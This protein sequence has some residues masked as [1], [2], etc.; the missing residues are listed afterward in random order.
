MTSTLIAPAD[1]ATPAQ[2]RYLNDLRVQRGMAVYDGPTL[3]KREASRLIDTTKALPIV[4]ATAP[5]VAGADAFASIPTGKY[6]FTADAGH[7]AFAQVNRP[8]RGRWVGRVFV[9]LL[10]G[11]P[12]DWRK[13]AQRG[14][15]ATTILAKI[16]AQGAEVSMARYGHEHGRC[17]ACESP[18]SDPVSI[19]RG[20]GPVCARRR[21]W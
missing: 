1:Q 11:A 19:A 16:E 21:G 13:I 6:A 17:G 3:A 12:G 4:R 7:T 15:S 18:L 8:T 20:I 14:A 9:D 5:R 10:V 2:L